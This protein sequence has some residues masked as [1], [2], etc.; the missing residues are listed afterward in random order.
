MSKLDKFEDF[1]A[2]L[3]SLA[4]GE[5]GVRPAHA[6]GNFALRQANFFAGRDQFLDKSI[7]KS[8]M[9]TVSPFARYTGLRLFPFLH[10][11]SVVNA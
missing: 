2:A 10:L 3:A 4:F 8:L 6:G 5:E 11:S 9:G 7:V 1:D